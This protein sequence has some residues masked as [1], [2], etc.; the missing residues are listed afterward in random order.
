MK[1]KWSTTR[2]FLSTLVTRFRR[3]DQSKTLSGTTLQKSSPIPKTALEAHARLH[4]I[5]EQS[6]TISTLNHEEFMSGWVAIAYIAPGLNPDEASM[7]DGGWPQGW[8]PIATEAFRRF[9]R[10]ELTKEELYPRAIR[11]L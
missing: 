5:L 1:W 10:E 7:E 2:L 9:A 3:S 11:L 6:T 4:D 8:R